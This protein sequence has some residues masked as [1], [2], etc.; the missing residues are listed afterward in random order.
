VGYNIIDVIEKAI[1]IEK[2]GKIQIQREIAENEIIPAIKLISK[3]LCNEI[4]ETIRYYENLKEEVKN[5]EAEEIDIR[6]YDKISFLINEFN[7]RIYQINVVSVRNFLKSL[8]DL[9]KDKYSLF[10]DIQGR[11]V[12]NSGN[13]KTKTYDV[14]SKI[15]KK[16]QNQINDIEKTIL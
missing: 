3:I 8:L 2:K 15:I 16:M 13:A 9:S 5:I 10:I 12:N 14:L 1:N 7:K 4:D 6:T 11:L